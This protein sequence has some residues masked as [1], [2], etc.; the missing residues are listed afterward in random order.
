MHLDVFFLLFSGLRFPHGVRPRQLLC[1]RRP[2]WF[3]TSSDLWLFSLYHCIYLAEC[4]C[5]YLLNA[6]RYL[7]SLN[8]FSPMST[9]DF[10]TNGIELI[11]TARHVPF[12]A[13]FSSAY[14]IYGN[15]LSRLETPRFQ[16]LG[17]LCTAKHFRTR[18]VPQQPS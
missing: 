4:I 9:L 17:F 12:K 3:S 6:S 8:V 16:K 7:D 14:H 18:T 1:W 11:D 13:C 5:M 10:Y 15:A 2:R